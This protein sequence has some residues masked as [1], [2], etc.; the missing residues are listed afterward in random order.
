M[1]IDKLYYRE[2]KAK[3]PEKVKASH[4]RYRLKNPIK[5]RESNVRW[6]LKNKEQQKLYYK[7]Y[8]L[9]PRSK[10]R[11]YRESASKRGYSFELT[12]ETFQSLILSK[13]CHY[14]GKEGKV[15]IDR[16]LN[17]IGYLV[18]N[19]VA[20]CW[21]CNRLKKTMNGGQYVS[22]CIAVA[23]NNSSRDMAN[24]TI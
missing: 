10:F 16:V 19:V 4:L 24:K 5:M 14:C 7:H 1:I 15:G 11:K 20:C 13:K 21:P 17:K 8:R 18:D 22:L 3:N 23:K 12:F 9:T 2:W 6:R